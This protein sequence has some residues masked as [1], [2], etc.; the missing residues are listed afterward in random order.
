MSLFLFRQSILLFKPGDGMLAAPALLLH[1]S[2]APTTREDHLR[3][4]LGR[5]PTP[6]QIRNAYYRRAKQLHPDSK[7]TSR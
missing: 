6:L 1:T 4:G 5:H 3:L 7:P 2:P